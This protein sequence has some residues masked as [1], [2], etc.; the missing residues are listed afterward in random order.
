MRFFTTAIVGLAAVISVVFADEVTCEAGKLAFDTCYIMFLQ[1][2][3]YYDLPSQR[4]KL[5]W[6]A[7]LLNALKIRVGHM[8]LII[9]HQVLVLC[10]RH[11]SF[12]DTQLCIAACT[13][14]KINCT[15][16]CATSKRNVSL[17]GLS[18][19]DTI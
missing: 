4:A 19:V 14:A 1:A 17:K 9:C 10:S 6:K 16:A 15:T 7:A 8:T 11:R 18:K 2:H 12:S 3:K 13:S 5:P